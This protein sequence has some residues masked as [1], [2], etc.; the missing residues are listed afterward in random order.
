MR[1]CFVHLVGGKLARPEALPRLQAAR[2]KVARAD[3]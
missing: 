1:N 2:V 3:Y